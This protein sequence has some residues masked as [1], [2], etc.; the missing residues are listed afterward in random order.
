ML[1]QA[2]G[3]RSSGAAVTPA[4][5]RF[6]MFLELSEEASVE[7]DD[8]DPSD[9]QTR[10]AMVVLDCKVWRREVEAAAVGGTRDDS[11]SLAPG[12]S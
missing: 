9:K 4:L 8:A 10:L 6:G 11:G 1:K 12:W 7:A 3:E 2:A 5:L